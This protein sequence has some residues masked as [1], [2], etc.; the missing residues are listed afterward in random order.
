MGRSVR[1]VLGH[2]DYAAFADLRREAMR[3]QL[4]AQ[5]AKQAMQGGLPLTKTGIAAID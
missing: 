1:R 2:E 4:E 5:A 3:S